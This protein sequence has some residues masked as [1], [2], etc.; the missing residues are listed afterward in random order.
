MVESLYPKP[1]ALRWS[2]YRSS[3]IAEASRHQLGAFALFN[4]AVLGSP[5]DPSVEL[6]VYLSL[7][8]RKNPELADAGAVIPLDTPIRA[9]YTENESVPGQDVF[10][11][12]LHRRR[13]RAWICRRCWRGK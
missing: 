13:D 2:R 1:R 9:A 7:R 4:G 8:A 11:R 10:R 6:P 5:A 3:H 12:R